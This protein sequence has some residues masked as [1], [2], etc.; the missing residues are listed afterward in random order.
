MRQFYVTYAQG[1]IGQ[2]LYDQFKDMSALCIRGNIEYKQVGHEKAKCASETLKNARQVPY[3]SI[4]CRIQPQQYH[5]NAVAVY[6]AYPN[7]ATLSHKLSWSHYV[8]QLKIGDPQER[9]FYMY[10]C[11]P[12]AV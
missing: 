4:W 8:E 1:Q 6:L 3:K 7:C 11:E 10:E 9:S 2:A 5:Q 12:E